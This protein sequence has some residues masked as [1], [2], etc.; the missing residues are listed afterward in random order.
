MKASEILSN[1]KQIKYFLLLE[2][3]RRMNLCKVWAASSAAGI[4]VNLNIKSKHDQFGGLIRTLSS[5]TQLYSKQN[6]CRRRKLITANT[7]F[8]TPTPPHLSLA[9]IEL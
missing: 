4:S 7:H 6:G 3:E 2:T 9:E 8:Y 5:V 1:K